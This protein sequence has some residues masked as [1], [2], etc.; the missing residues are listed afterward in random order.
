MNAAVKNHE[1][2]SIIRKE[3]VRDKISAHEKEVKKQFCR[4]IIKTFLAH[5]SCLHTHA[6]S[7][8]MV[9]HC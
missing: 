5:L 2:A 7:K 4:K 8:T 6:E 3:K 1:F 9:N